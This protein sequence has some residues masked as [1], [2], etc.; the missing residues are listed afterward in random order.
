MIRTLV[1]LCQADEQGEYG[2]TNRKH[3][4]KTYIISLIVLYYIC[5]T[6]LTLSE[7]II[8]TMT[9]ILTGYFS[10]PSGTVN[11][12]KLEVKACY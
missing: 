6:I 3:F 7:Q 1:N 11:D 5:N 4:Y 10:S 8:F 2:K 9:L 12:V